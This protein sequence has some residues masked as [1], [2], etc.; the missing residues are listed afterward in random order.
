MKRMRKY[1]I[2]INRC[3]YRK[4][5][6][7]MEG[8]TLLGDI[9]RLEKNRGKINWD[10]IEQKYRAPLEKF[11]ESFLEDLKDLR[12]EK[13]KPGNKKFK[14]N[15]FEERLRELFKNV[16]GDRAK[17]TDERPK[18]QPRKEFEDCFKPNKK[19]E[20]D[21]KIAK[22]GREDTGSP[23]FYIEIKYNLTIDNLGAALVEAIITKRNNKDKFFVISFYETG[24]KRGNIN[25]KELCKKSPFRE[26]IDGVVCFGPEFDHELRDVVELLREIDNTY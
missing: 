16:I 23:V 11:Y 25:Y 6:Y 7:E 10:K 1:L 5:V 8:K 20:I 26:Y 3:L 2:K 15:R 21:I 17:V 24:R 13:I 4:E 18:L 19:K 9:S 14:V 22:T 12:K